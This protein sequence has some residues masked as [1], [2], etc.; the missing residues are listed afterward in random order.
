[1]ENKITISVP[2]GYIFSEERNGKLIFRKA[3]ERT[4]FE[5]AFARSLEQI[6][7]ELTYEK[8]YDKEVEALTRLLNT[9]NFYNQGW[10]PDWTNEEEFKY[11]VIVERG[12]PVAWDETT[13]Q[14]PLYFK[15]EETRDAF[16]H[17]FEDLIEQAK[18]LL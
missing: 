17:H 10:V 5:I 14:H 9:R 1:M 6:R 11:C 18:E 12:R 13:V 4:Y 3:D 16:M 15:S 2:D 7:K 8:N